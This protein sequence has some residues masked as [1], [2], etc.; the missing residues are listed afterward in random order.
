MADTLGLITQVLE[1]DL[2]IYDPELDN[3]KHSTEATYTNLIAEGFTK[4]KTALEGMDMKPE[5]ILQS[6]SS[7]YKQVHIAI[8]LMIIYRR[9]I[10][11]EGDRASILAEKYRQEYLEQLPQLKIDYDRDESGTIEEDEE[12]RHAGFVMDR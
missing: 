11:E 6:D 2:K 4:L 8:T 3:Y 1:A 10:K 9:A 5:L 7:K 12:N